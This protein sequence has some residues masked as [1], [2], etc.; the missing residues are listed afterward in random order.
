VGVGEEDQ[1]VQE[2][3][4][5]AAEDLDDCKPGH[6]VA[7]NIFFTSYSICTYTSWLLI[8]H[9]APVSVMDLF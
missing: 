3:C 2:A 8:V 9:G 1:D 5:I 6:L 7:F 4:V